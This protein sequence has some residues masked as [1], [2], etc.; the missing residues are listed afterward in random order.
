MNL[1]GCR[2]TTVDGVAVGAVSVRMGLVR[3]RFYGSVD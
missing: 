1:K 2:Y 3:E